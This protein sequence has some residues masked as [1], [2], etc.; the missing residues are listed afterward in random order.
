MKKA[1]SIL[2]AI[3]MCLSVLPVFAARSFDPP[4]KG[5]DII[6]SG[7]CGENAFW[8]LTEDGVLTVYGSGAT[9]DYA[10][11]MDPQNPDSANVPWARYYIDAASSG[12]ETDSDGVLCPIVKSIVVE[13]GITEIGTCL[14]Y[15]MN[16]AESVTL[17]STLTSIGLR[18]FFWCFSLKCIKVPD[19]VTSIG[20]SAFLD[21]RS[22]E[23]L[24]LPESLAEVGTGAFGK[25]S[26]LKSVKI[27]AG[28]IT[29]SRAMFAYCGSLESVYFPVV[30]EIG[31]YAFYNCS[32]LKDVYYPGSKEAWNKVKI[33]SNN[34]KL[35]KATK[36]YYYN[37]NYIPYCSASIKYATYAYKGT[38]IK[39]TVT[40]TTAS[41]TKLTKGT[42]YTVSYKNNIDY[43]T[44]TITV[45]GKGKYYGT[46]TITF[47]IRPAKVKDLKVVSCDGSTAVVSWTTDPLSEKYKVCLGADLV[48]YT[49]ADTYTVSGLVPGKARKIWVYAIGYKTDPDTGERIA[50][51]SNGSYVW[52]NK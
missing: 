31:E 41:G 25:C 51:K 46:Q 42:H 21:C 7:I 16:N 43:G 39:P 18:T 48:G 29:L 2:F 14:F 37:Y 38:E 20:D 45:T 52:V 47:R 36:H 3:L 28:I 50:Y 15:G 40:L 44:A 30:K 35:K 13:E 4:V 32:S 19:G 9:Y 26:A 24:I 6:D 23:E 12:V 34:G 33:G 11:Y 8:K 1:I 10:Y 22:L 49:K 17:P 27:P 5:S